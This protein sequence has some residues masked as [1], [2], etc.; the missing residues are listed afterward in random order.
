MIKKIAVYCGARNGKGDAFKKQAYDLGSW[1][2]RRNI[3]LVYGGG[4]YGLMRAVADGV[5]DN[6]GYVHGVITKELKSRGAAYSRVQDLRLAKNM[7]TRK[8]LMMDLSDG[9]IVL[10]GGIGTLEEASQA[11][12]WTAVGDNSKPVAFYNY[13]DF[14]GNLQKLLQ[15]MNENDFLEAEYLQAMF[16]GD[17]F[18]DIL[19]FMDSYKAPKYRQY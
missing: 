11:I 8:D 9:M 5:L 13:E 18:K 19:D 4:K 17:R 16:F 14:Y 7:S 6:G 15:V 1:L 2:A 10:P 3:E 12:S